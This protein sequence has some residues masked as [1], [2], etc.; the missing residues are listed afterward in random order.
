[1]WIGILL[2][3]AVLSAQSA[4][5]QPGSIQL[6][7]SEAGRE[8]IYLDSR[9]RSGVSFGHFLRI[10]R[11]NPSLPDPFMLQTWSEP[12]LDCSNAEFRCV[13]GGSIIL[14]SPVGSVSE[15]QS[16]RYM[17][18]SARVLHCDREGVCTFEI[19]PVDLSVSPRPLVIYFR[20]SDCGIL[21][22]G[23]EPIA[24]NSRRAS[25]RFRLVGRE[26][27]FARAS[28]PHAN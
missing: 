16:F 24:G 3:A 9:R 7:K 5:A 27:L 15:G 6:G 10:G 20:Q 25:R 19:T 17:G 2:V 11:F 1:M 18:R 8:I 13:M 12:L 28:A 26:G 4:L 14:F 22:L 21:S 23:L